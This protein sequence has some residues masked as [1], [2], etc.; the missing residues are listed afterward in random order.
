MTTES[1]AGLKLKK[2]LQ[3]DKELKACPEIRVHY[4]FSSF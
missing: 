4:L 1:G 2:L 3:R